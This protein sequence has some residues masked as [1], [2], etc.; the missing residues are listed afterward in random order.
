MFETCSAY[1]ALMSYSSTLPYFLKNTAEVFIRTSIRTSINVKRQSFVGILGEAVCEGD[2]PRPKEPLPCGD[3]VLGLDWL[4]DYL[5]QERISWDTM[6]HPPLLR[7]TSNFPNA[8]DSS[9]ALM[10]RQ[11]TRSW[12]GEI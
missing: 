1:S 4:A 2:H 8:M 3:D 10:Q 6:K 9:T 11:R 7:K 5:Y 12:K